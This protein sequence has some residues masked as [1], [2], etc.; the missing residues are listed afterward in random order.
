MYKIAL[1]GFGY[2]GQI[3]LKNIEEEVGAGLS[4]C[5]V[6]EK[7]ID[8]S[9]MQKRYKHYRSIDEIPNSVQYVFVATPVSTHYKICRKL[10]LNNRSVEI[11]C[12]KPLGE[13]MNQVKELYKIAEKDRIFVDWTYLYN[14]AIDV[15][16]SMQKSYD[17]GSLVSVYMNRKNMGPVRKDCDA[18]KDLA[19][20]DIS[21]L[22]RLSD[23][24]II[25]IPEWNKF[26]TD[27][28][29]VSDTAMGLT[30]LSSS[31]SPMPIPVVINVSWNFNKKDRLCQFNYEYGIIEWDDSQ[32]KIWTDKD[33]D[34]IDL[35]YKTS[36]LK[37][38]ITSFFDGEFEENKKATL[39]ISELIS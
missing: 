31:I 5:I 12:E 39:R 32:Q 6:E 33:P 35:S 2:W 8:W 24:N 38:A 13:N 9:H 26:Y 3:L 37:N 16:N 30:F 20:H 11:F 17:L 10:L 29:H 21:I 25:E 1:V 4:I 28:N 7:D 14:D 19:C 34:A 23:A 18:V 27:N 15:I 22:T 36:P